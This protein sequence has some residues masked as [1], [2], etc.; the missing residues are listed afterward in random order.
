MAEI[1]D[2]G[3]W[4]IHR[5]ASACFRGGEGE[6]FRR[7]MLTLAAT[8]QKQPMPPGRGC[9]FTWIPS[10]AALK[11]AFVLGKKDPMMRWLPEAEVPGHEDAPRVVATYDMQKEFVL[12]A[13]MPDRGYAALV[14]LYCTIQ[15]GIGVGGLGN[16]VQAVRVTSGIDKSS[17]LSNF[18]E[19]CAWCEKKAESMPKCMRC[20][21]VFYCNK[22]CQKAHWKQHKKTCN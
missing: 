12:W 8:L 2:V 7:L 4:T 9:Y 15:S 20:K 10:H 21:C 5:S 1:R 17:S 19:V 6:I 18:F 13:Q 16:P 3:P 22:A 14:P 11:D